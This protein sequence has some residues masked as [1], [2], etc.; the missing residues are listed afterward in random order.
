MRSFR[1]VFAVLGLAVMGGFTMQAHA[2]DLPRVPD[3]APASRVAFVGDSL[4]YGMG[5]ATPHSLNGGIVGSGLSVGNPDRNFQHWKSFSGKGDLTLV[6]IGTNDFGY[7]EGDRYQALLSRYILP[8]ADKNALCIV[9][10]PVPEKESIKNGVVARSKTIREWAVSNGISVVEPLYIPQ[11]RAK[12]GIHFSLAGYKSMA[13][14][15]INSCRNYHVG[16]PVDDQ[17]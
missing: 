5:V 9:L 17:N 13:A 11:T 3:P 14:S 1:S 2:A 16:V 4:A 15:A 6:E 7:T 12:D 10:P 8:L